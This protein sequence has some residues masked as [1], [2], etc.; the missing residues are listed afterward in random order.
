MT[1]ISTLS[2]TSAARSSSSL[3]F[4]RRISSPSLLQYFALRCSSSSSRSSSPSAEEL[5]KVVAGVTPQDIE[6]NP[7]IADFLR[8]NYADISSSS[9]TEE[10]TSWG[11]LRRQIPKAPLNIRSMPTL[12]RDPDTEEGTNKSFLLRDH[13]MIPGVIYG[14]DPTKGIK[15]QDLNH[16]IFVKTPTSVIQSE[17][18]R[19]HHSF[20][21]RVYD[22]T[23]YDN[24]EAL[25]SGNGGITHRVIPRNVQRHPVNDTVYCCNYLRYFPG[26]AIKL[27]LLLI[28]EEES[29]ALKRDGYLIP[30]NRYVECV[31]EDGVPIPEELEVEC[32]GLQFKQVIRLDRVI[33]P[34]GVKPSKKV[35]KRG[36]EFIIGPIHGGKR[37]KDDDA[38]EA[39]S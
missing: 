17:I 18:D 27:P 15:G 38:G 10:Q 39:E 31:I 11:E 9:T 25:T 12:K 5:S 19:Y 26:R 21:S 34:E 7:V 6:S 23:L 8:S 22:I 37:D 28:N 33:F 16:R 32:T 24:E 30:I 14:G 3:L 29:P 36:K 1:L 35:L 13:G 20:E 2:S 4:R